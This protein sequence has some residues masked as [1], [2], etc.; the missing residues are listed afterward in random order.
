MANT[1]ERRIGLAERRRG[2]RI[3]R[4]RRLFVDLG[5]IGLLL[6]ASGPVAAVAGGDHGH[7]SH[8]EQA[9][10]TPGGGPGGEGDGG[11]GGAPAGYSSGEGGSQGAS[12]D[13]PSGGS[14]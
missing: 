12:G 9:A 7:G 10:G 3:G 8:S 4:S 14:G 5:I 13:G 1:E 11:S 6:I 2:A